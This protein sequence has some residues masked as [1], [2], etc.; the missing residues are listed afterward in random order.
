MKFAKCDNCSC[1][2]FYVNDMVCYGEQCFCNKKCKDEYIESCLT[3]DDMDDFIKHGEVQ[4][5]EI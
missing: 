3:Y 5:N 4:K 2:I 1:E